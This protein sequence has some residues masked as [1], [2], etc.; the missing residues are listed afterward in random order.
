MSFDEEV[1]RNELYDLLHYFSK[2]AYRAR[3]TNAKVETCLAGRQTVYICVGSF[4]FKFSLG[5]YC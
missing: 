1:S 2:N 4:T 5:Y 3:D